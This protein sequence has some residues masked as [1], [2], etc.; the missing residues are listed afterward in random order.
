MDG[1]VQYRHG[2]L[3][4][5]YP[6]VQRGDLVAGYQSTPDKRIVALARV[7]REFQSV[8]GN[9]PTIELEPLSRVGSAPTYDE[10]LADPALSRSEPMRFRNQGTLF[11][12]SREEAD[13]LMSRLVERN[14]DLASVEAA[15]GAAGETAVGPLT[16]VTFHPSYTYEDFI[17]GSRPADTG[18]ETLSL[19]LEDGIFKRV[20]RAAQAHPDQTYLLLVDEI[21]RGNVARILGEL[22]TLLERDKRGFT[23][24][25]PQSK[26]TFTIPQN[27]YLLGT[28]N[29]ADRSIK[30]LDAALRRRFAFIE[31]M[32]D[33]ELLRGATVG[34]LALDDFLEGLNRRIAAEE[35]REKQIG[36]AYLL[37]DGQPIADPEV[38]ARRFREEILPL[39]QEYC[40]DEYATLAKY[41]GSTLVDAGGQQ[42]DQERL[43]DP[44]QLIAALAR[45]FGGEEAGEE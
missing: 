21:N 13:Y 40:Y 33:A 9:P 28:M 24:T 3:Q 11:A 27:V 10:L 8:D 17:E 29:T 22:L 35:G 16:R 5:N 25:L 15:E 7:S 18:G 38:F 20:C 12:L 32:P 6:L 31:L 43:E 23:V 37:D 30:L 2:R 42:L 39:L 14:L 44:E 26:E 19:R 1:R 34:E 4:R 45:E 41:I 36:H